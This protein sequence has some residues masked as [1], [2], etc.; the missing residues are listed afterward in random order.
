MP[1]VADVAL[2]VD[3]DVDDDDDGGGDD[4]VVVVVVVVVAAAVIVVCCCCSG[5]RGLIAR[6]DIA[7]A[8]VFF[9]F[10]Y[11][12]ALRKRKPRRN[13][14]NIICKLVNRYRDWHKNSVYIL[15]CQLQRWVD[16]LLLLH[17]SLSFL[18][19]HLGWHHFALA[20]ILVFVVVSTDSVYR[21]SVT[22]I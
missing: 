15:H 18:S 20:K 21:Y 8:I 3:N 12:C 16:I 13:K 17:C 1:D 2:V 6:H 7:A 22:Y 5:V 9:W 19:L 14:T 10:V 11:V 4:V